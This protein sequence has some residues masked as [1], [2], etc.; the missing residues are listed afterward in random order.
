MEQDTPPVTPSFRTTRIAA[1]QKLVIYAIVLNLATIFVDWGELIFI[2]PGL[3]CTLMALVG[4]FRLA[5]AFGYS[6][7]RKC[8]LV[9]GMLIPLVN[10]LVLAGLS[11]RA[12][13]ELRE[14]GIKVGLLGAKLPVSAVEDNSAAE[15]D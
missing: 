9:I 12:S 1:A 6:L 11:I 4:M 5:S 2:I 3:I 14:A 7:F 8:L 15:Q 13:R 10:L